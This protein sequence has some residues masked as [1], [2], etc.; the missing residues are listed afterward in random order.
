MKRISVLGLGYI[1]LPTAIIAAQ[2][3]YDVCGF[4]TDLEKVKQINSGNPVIFEPEISERLWKVLQSGFFKAHAELQ[5]A[6]AFVIA[7]P[8]PFKENNHADVSY[9]FSAAASIAK[10]LMPGNLI[11]IE[12]TVPVGTTEKVAQYLE[13]H[14]GLKLGIDFF[15]SYAPERVLPGHIF[16]EIVENERT[17]GGVCQQASQLAQLFY[18]KFVRGFVHITDD[19]S[20]EMIKLVENANRDVQIAFANQVAAMCQQANVDPYH[21]IALANRHPRVKILNPTCGVGGHCIAVDPFFLIE[22]FPEH[23]ALLQAAR[24]INDAKPGTVFKNIMARVEELAVRNIKRP[25]VFVMGLAFKPDVDDIRQSPALQIAEALRD[26]KDRLD[27]QVYDHNVP[28]VTI[29]QRHFETASDVWR[30][31][32]WADVIAILVKHKEFLL[33]QQ[34]VFGEKIVIDTCGLFHDIKAKQSHAVLEGAMKSDPL[35]W[36]TLTMKDAA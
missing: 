1:G 3:G 17:I 30:G 25:K 32:E 13:E 18:S 29:Q 26:Q 12:S 28:L 31:I 35:F 19:K 10:R 21:V 6:D 24:I 4:D 15:V 8:T 9:V 7:V 36:K 11:I 27:L 22:T 16:R 23:T 20:A 34:D 33:M 5:Y 14:S 2:S